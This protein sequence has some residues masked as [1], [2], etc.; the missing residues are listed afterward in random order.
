[1]KHFYEL[2]HNGQHLSFHTSYGRARIRVMNRTNNLSLGKWKRISPEVEI[3]VL[4]HEV[5]TL[6][7]HDFYDE[8][9]DTG[10][11]EG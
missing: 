10:A 11:Q 5:Y 2:K 3:C 9:L 4:A 6:A 1:M 7:K 8:N